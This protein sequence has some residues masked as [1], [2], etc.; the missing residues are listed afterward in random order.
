[1]NDS[2]FTAFP[3]TNDT[4]LFEFFNSE[5]SPE[6]AETLANTGKFVSEDPPTIFPAEGGRF[7]VLY[8][9]VD[10]SEYIAALWLSFPNLYAF[11][12]L[13]LFL[14][15]ETPAPWTGEVLRE[16]EALNEEFAVTVDAQTCWRGSN[17]DDGNATDFKLMTEELA[18][19]VS[20]HTEIFDDSFG[21]V[22]LSRWFTAFQ[23]T[24][25]SINTP[26]DKTYFSFRFRR[27]AASQAAFR[28]NS[29]GYLGNCNA[30]TAILCTPKLYAEGRQVVYGWDYGL[31]LLFLLVV[32]NVW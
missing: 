17:C 16:Y 26:F 4:Q 10:N 24:V 31:L 15:M 13:T 25:A 19:T 32:Y 6:G 11:H 23:Y 20:G 28:I 29:D 9:E 27:N 7:T 2:P 3:L 1:M 18:V 12:Q 30:T 14:S 5:L 22:T 8:D 21:S